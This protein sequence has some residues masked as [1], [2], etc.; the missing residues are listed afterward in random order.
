MILPIH[1]AKRKKISILLDTGATL[2]LIKLRNLE[3]ETP[4]REERMVLTGITGHKIHT[5]GKIRATISPR[6]RRIRHT[7]YMVKNSIDY[8]GILRIDFFQK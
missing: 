4:M 5:I 7:I 8:E 3:D 6:N 2:I 1:E